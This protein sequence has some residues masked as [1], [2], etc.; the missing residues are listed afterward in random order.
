MGNGESTQQNSRHWFGHKQILL[1]GDND[2]PVA[3]IVGPVNEWDAQHL[4]KL[5]VI[6]NSSG[7]APILDV[8][9]TAHG[10]PYAAVPILNYPT[11]Q[12]LLNDED[13]KWEH[14]AGALRAAA[15]I[16]QTA[17]DAKVTHGGLAP[18]LISVRDSE[19][20]INGL[21][22]A[23]GGEFSE[24]AQQWMAPEVL[25]GQAPDEYSDI[26]SFG[27]MLGAALESAEQ[28]PRSLSR[29]AKWSTS[30][31]AETRPPSMEEF[32]NVIGETLG[33]D[34][35][36][37]PGY[38]ATTAYATTL[39][40]SD[41]SSLKPASQDIAFDDLRDKQEERKRR[42]EV[43]APTPVIVDEAERSYSWITAACIVGLGIV[44]S[45]WIFQTSDT[46]TATPT[47]DL[48]SPT[49]QQI[50]SDGSP[51][52]EDAEQGTETEA[53]DQL[54]PALDVDA[55]GIQIVHGIAD[56]EVDLYIDDQYPGFCTRNTGWSGLYRT[57]RILGCAV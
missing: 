54:N 1:E 4:D 10:Q 55:A 32:A 29:L 21:G 2:H 38:V 44:L 46:E 18:E 56:T 43:T 26:F 37:K 50:D 34:Y 13:M 48:S 53:S 30:E 31:T 45:F 39:G 12:D 35:E 36:F 27:A 6:S 16:M 52:A 28:R 51:N 5:K 15:E 42:D 7:I 22:F 40:S 9:F 23:P 33:A 47:T 14:K 8:D 49:T 20:I 17:H 11:L 24:A 19:V 25:E 3:I 57:W 41:N